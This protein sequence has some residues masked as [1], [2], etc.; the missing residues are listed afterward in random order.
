MITSPLGIHDIAVIDVTPWKTVVGQNYMCNINLTVTNEGN[1]AETFNLTLY[2]DTTVIYTYTN[3]TLPSGNSTTITFT[4]DITGCSKGNY[5][6]WAYAWPIL[7]ETY[8]ADNTF[9]DGWIIISLVGDI[10]AD[11]IVDI[12]DI[13]AIALGFEETPNRPRW[14]PNLDINHDEIID[15]EDMYLAALNYG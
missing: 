14:D 2:A 3:I 6:I 7:G 5:T 11:G 15:I 13:Y 9:T 8:T 12:E 4:W 1:F 10:N